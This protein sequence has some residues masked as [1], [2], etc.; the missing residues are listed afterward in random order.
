MIG[1][2]I[3]TIINSRIEV[4]ELSNKI[5]FNIDIPPIVLDEKLT[6]KIYRIVSELI[7]NS[8][9]HAQCKNINIQFQKNN[10][11]YSLDYI[12]DGI[13][14]DKNNKRNHGINNI[15]SRVNFV[16][17][18]IDLFSIPGKTHYSIQIPITEN[19]K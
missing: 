11:Y 15:E 19:E 8:I 14:F 13:G 3:K 1:K 7:T 4:L 10:D 5:N 18:T 12:D 2:D 9:K 6:L 17:G 16:N